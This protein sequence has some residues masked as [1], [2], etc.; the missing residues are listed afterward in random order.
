MI[1]EMLYDLTS[2]GL[3][4]ALMVLAVVL[5]AFFALMIGVGITLFGDALRDFH[6]AGMKRVERY[7]ARTR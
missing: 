7:E 3:G 6:R 5:A 2:V 4:L 1:E